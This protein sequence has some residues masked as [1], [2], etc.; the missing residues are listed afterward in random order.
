MPQH[1]F[2]RRGIKRICP[3]SQRWGM[4]KNP[5]LF[6]NSEITCQIP[7]VHFSASIVRFVS[8]WYTAPLVVK[9]GSPSSEG[10]IGLTKP[11]C[12]INPAK[13]PLPLAFTAFGNVT[14]QHGLWQCYLAAQP[15]AMLPCST[16]SGNV[17]KLT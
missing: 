16:A 15:V 5:A 12:R 17:L 10:T 6:V 8:D 4:F 1:A 9:E 13:R 7:L 2:L 3:L 14:L 11:Q